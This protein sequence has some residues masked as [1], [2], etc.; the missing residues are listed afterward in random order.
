MAKQAASPEKTNTHSA[1][2]RAH[3]DNAAGPAGVA[4]AP[5]SYG[6]DVLDQPVSEDLTEYESPEGVLQRQAVSFSAGGTPPEGPPEEEELPFPLQ[7]KLKIGPVNDKYEWEADRVAEQVM[8]MPAPSLQRQSCACGKSDGPDGMC[9]DCQRKQLGIQRVA[10]GSTAQTTA[11]PIVHQVLRQPGRPLDRSTRN[12]MEPRFGQ[13][14]SQVRV[15]TDA[16]AAESAQAVN[17]RAFTLGRNVVFGAGEYSSGT[18]SRRRLLAHELTHVVQQSG[19]GYVREKRALKLV[20]MLQK[21][22][23]LPQ[24][25]S[26]S[27]SR[28]HSVGV[29]SSDIGIARQVDSSTSHHPSALRCSASFGA[30][31]EGFVPAYLTVGGPVVLIPIL[32]FFVPSPGWLGWA[33]GGSLEVVFNCRSGDARAFASITVGI[34]PSL[35]IILISVV[36]GG[37]IN[38]IYDLPRTRDYAGHFL[39]VTADFTIGPAGNYVTGF[40]TPAGALNLATTGSFGGETHGFGLGYAMGVP[41][42]G[43]IG[44]WEY[45]WD[46]GAIPFSPADIRSEC[47][48][49]PP[50]VGDYPS[51]PTRATSDPE[52]L[53]R[54]HT[55]VAPVLPRLKESVIRRV[56][57]NLPTVISTP[58]VVRRI[59]ASQWS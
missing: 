55:I 29:G 8:R 46:L 7:A 37:G 6:L 17:A 58:D 22:D 2:P 28:H 35:S 43:V 30:D 49:P 10:S 18:S 45:F 41:S 57:R 26:G 20:H 24:Q 38:F 5:P 13:D 50:P 25:D 48:C 11:S 14:F 15:H 31:A 34:G 4:V 52:R 16:K 32:G 44:H 56:E 42:A 3:S 53:A 39:G 1:E 27:D 36:A 33:V 47:L 59:R 40:T 19:G 21:G 12:F 23:A 51:S 9:A 54:L